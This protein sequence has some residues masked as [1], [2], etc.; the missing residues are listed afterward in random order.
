MCNTFLGGGKNRREGKLMS[1]QPKRAQ[2]T[3]AP[4]IN[5]ADDLVDI[6]IASNRV[7]ANARDINPYEV[8]NALLIRE[9]KARVLYK[10][11]VTLPTSAEVLFANALR[12]DY[13]HRRTLSRNIVAATSQP[14]PVDACAHHIVAHRDSEATGSRTLLYRWGI[15]INDADNG[16]F[17]PSKGIGLPGHPNAPRHDPHHRAAYHVAVYVQLRRGRDVES[18]RQRLRSIKTQLLS[19]VLAL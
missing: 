12:K 14:R 5:T 9:E 6:S 4:P 2:T 17:L 10:N 16:V 7:S 19:G 1:A 13:N 3:A 15:G 11:G 18:G 8:R